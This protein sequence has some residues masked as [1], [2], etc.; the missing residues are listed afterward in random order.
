M[1]GTGMRVGI[2]AQ[3]HH[4]V[5]LAHHP[6]LSIDQQTRPYS[7]PISAASDLS[8]RTNEPRLSSAEMTRLRKEDRCFRCKEVADHR[9]RCTKLWQPMSSIPTA[10]VNE[11]ASTR[12]ENEVAVP[13]P[14]HIEKTENA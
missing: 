7:R 11:M 14:G 6:K 12:G 8:T 4:L 5:S 9:P 13:R 3:D 1:V 2:L 10:R